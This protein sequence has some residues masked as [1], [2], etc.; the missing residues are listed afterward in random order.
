MVSSLYRE[1]F[2][3]QQ[4]DVNPRLGIMAYTCNPSAPEAG[5]S[6]QSTKNDK[7]QL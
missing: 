2:S 7:H 6:A 5:R 1:D 3:K 4:K